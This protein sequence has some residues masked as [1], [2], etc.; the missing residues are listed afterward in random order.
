MVQG[1]GLGDNTPN[2]NKN[3]DK[4][5]KKETTSR[6]HDDFKEK[7]ER[8]RGNDKRT[9]DLKASQPVTKST[10]KPTTKRSSV[11]R[12]PKIAEGKGPDKPDKKSRKSKMLLAVIMLIVFIIILLLGLNYRTLTGDGQ[13]SDELVDTETE[14]YGTEATEA[15]SAEDEL[16]ASDSERLALESASN[17]VTHNPYSLKGLRQQLQQEGFSPNAVD[18][19]VTEIDTAFGV[20]WDANAVESAERF[21]AYAMPEVSEKVLTEQLLYEGFTGDEIAHALDNVDKSGF[22]ADDEIPETF[23]PGDELDEQDQEDDQDS[24][25]VDDDNHDSD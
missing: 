24:D 9:V 15:E 21:I 1:M 10:D 4:T 16:Y 19:A 25:E 2:K 12:G 18:F 22:K 13:E 8:K 5:K 7:K 14:H 23:L 3:T 6:R 11:P 17:H 20:D